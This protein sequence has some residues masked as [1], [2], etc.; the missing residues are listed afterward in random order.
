[1]ERGD[2]IASYQKESKD[3]EDLIR[4]CQK[5]KKDIENEIDKI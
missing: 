3:Y 1:M 2:L 5:Q 4:D